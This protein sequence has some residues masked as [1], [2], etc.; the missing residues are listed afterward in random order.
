MLNSYH[1]EFLKLLSECGVRFM[2]IGG[3]A[4]HHYYGTETRDLD[5]WAQNDEALQRALAAWMESHPWPLPRPELRLW[6]PDDTQLHQTGTDEAAGRIDVL[7][8]VDGHV[9]RVVALGDLGLVSPP[10]S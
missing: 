5:V 6:H 1:R 7:T 10:P 4:R 2:V 3:Q 9:V 8:K